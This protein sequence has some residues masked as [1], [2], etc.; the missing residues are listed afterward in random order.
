LILS[1]EVDVH[2]ERTVHEPRKIKV[3][4][5]DHYPF[6]ACGMGIFRDPFLM[7]LSKRLRVVL[8]GEFSRQNN[9]D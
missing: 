7:A 9:Q 8:V 5:G 1:E 3:P 4:R 2:R 6:G